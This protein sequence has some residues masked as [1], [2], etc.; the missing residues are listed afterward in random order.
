M[1]NIN[2]KTFQFG[3]CAKVGAHTTA[4]LLPVRVVKVC[5]RFHPQITKDWFCPQGRPLV[6]PTKAAHTQVGRMVIIAHKE[7]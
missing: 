7:R 5:R 1:E 3:L 6:L 2:T 4:L